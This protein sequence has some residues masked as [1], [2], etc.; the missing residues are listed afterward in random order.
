M[1]AVTVGNQDAKKVWQRRLHSCHHLQGRITW[2]Q[3]Y[4]VIIYLR[5]ESSVVE[6]RHG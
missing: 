6:L 2:V 3:E 1:I 5:R 4:S